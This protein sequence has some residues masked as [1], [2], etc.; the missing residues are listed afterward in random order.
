MNNNIK[1]DSKLKAGIH[2][3]IIQFGLLVIPII[4]MP[5][6][7]DKIGM[8]KFGAVIF[9]QSIMNLLSVIIN[10]GFA[11]TGAPDIAKAASG[12]KLN[13]EYSNILFSKIFLLFLCL[14]IALILYAVIPKFNN[15]KQLYFLSLIILVFNCLDISFLFQGVERMKDYMILNFLANILVVFLLFYFVKKPEDYILIPVIFF[16]PKVFASGAAILYA[17]VIFKIKPNMF[18]FTAVLRKL[19]NGINFF[20]SNI[21]SILYAQ[22]SSIMLGFLGGDI[23]VGIYSLADK[24]CIA[25]TIIQSKIAVV[26]QPQIAKDFKK[27]IIEGSIRAKENI[28]FTLIAAIPVFFFCQFFAEDILFLFFQNKGADSVN[29]LRM[30]SLN[31]ISI[32]LSGILSCNILISIG[33]ADEMLRPSVITAIINCILGGTLI[34]FFRHT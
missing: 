15:E 6:I 18:F 2:L 14:L 3:T 31:F 16:G 30:L 22:T 25:Y 10:Y 33:R 13:F 17:S 21:F 24:L 19:R 27:G 12:R 9:F 28:F 34:Y 11:Q 20:A 23:S 5:Y 4:T 1:R 32:G 8:E 26:Y 29:I 7:V